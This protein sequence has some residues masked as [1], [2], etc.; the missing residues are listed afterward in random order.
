[1]TTLTSKRLTVFAPVEHIH[2]IV[3]QYLRYID[4]VREDQHI[5]GV[6]LPLTLNE[7]NLVEIH[8]GLIDLPTEL[9]TAVN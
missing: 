8:V 2:T 3:E 1:M 4:V 5:A 7:E 9:S 6:A